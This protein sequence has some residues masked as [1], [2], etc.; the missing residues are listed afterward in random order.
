[1]MTLQGANLSHKNRTRLFTVQEHAQ[2]SRESS[3]VR[4]LKPYNP[5]V[6]TLNVDFEEMNATAELE[7]KTKSI[8]DD[9]HVKVTPRQGGVS[10]RRR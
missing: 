10:L 6:R 9:T 1:M 5:P 7:M 2:N 3:A 4:I 8:V